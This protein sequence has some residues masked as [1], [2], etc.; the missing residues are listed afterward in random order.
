MAQVASEKLSPVAK[1]MYVLPS[2]LHDELSNMTWLTGIQLPLTPIGTPTQIALLTPTKA[3]WNIRNEHCGTDS[4][5]TKHRTR[6]KRSKDGTWKKPPLHFATLMYIAL[7]NHQPP[8]LT[9]P[10]I[11]KYIADHFPYFQTV[12]RNW[13]VTVR[14]T[15]ETSASFVKLTDSECPFFWTVSPDQ[16]LASRDDIGKAL[17]EQRDHL[18]TSMS[19]PDELLSSPSFQTPYSPIEDYIPMI[20]IPSQLTDVESPTGRDEQPKTQGISSFVESEDW[21]LPSDGL[22]AGGE[23]GLLL[24]S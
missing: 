18:T 4:P 24:D 12:N 17:Q 2:T 15:L 23:T 16:I 14:S 21:K 13:K 1:P 10:Q 5:P 6:R 3:P 19:C 22:L 7:T 11:C 20:P 9:A 8:H